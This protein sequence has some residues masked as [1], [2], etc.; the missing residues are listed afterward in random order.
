MSGKS[1]RQIRKEANALR[2]SLTQE[3]KDTARDL[4]AELEASA[5]KY[6]FQFAM[7][8]MFHRKKKKD[9]NGRV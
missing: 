1:S 9:K 5:F 6:R 3:R 2:T 4:I 8:L 7:K